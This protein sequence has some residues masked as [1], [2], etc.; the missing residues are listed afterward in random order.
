MRP[1]GKKSIIRRCRVRGC[2][3]VWAGSSFC[4]QPHDSVVA[5]PKIQS[6][7]GNRPCEATATSRIRTFHQRPFQTTVLIPARSAG[8]DQ[9]RVPQTTLSEASTPHPDGVL[10]RVGAQALPD[11]VITLRAIRSIHS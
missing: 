1:R 3:I 2:A 10:W 7:R 9:T 11:V 8:E 6:G 4:G 5:P